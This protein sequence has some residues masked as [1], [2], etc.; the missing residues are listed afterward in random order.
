MATT[1]TSVT[2]GATSTAV[3]G[4]AGNRDYLAIINDSDEVIYLALDAAAVLNKG[5]RLNAYGGS[6]EINQDNPYVGP[7]NAICT[8]GG[9]VLTVT[10]VE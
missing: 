10:L 4:S 1:N 2:V 5:I 9:K 3:R 7:I 8:S 6:Y